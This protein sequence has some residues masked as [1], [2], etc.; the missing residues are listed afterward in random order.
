MWDT[1]MKKNVDPIQG[2]KEVSASDMGSELSPM[3]P[4]DAFNPPAQQ[5]ID[6]DELH[7]FLKQLVDE[8]IELKK[9]IEDL[10]LALE[11][12]KNKKITSNTFKYAHSF[13]EFFH[14][15]F[16]PHN[17]KEESQLFKLL[18]QKL[19]EKGEHSS[20]ENPFTGIQVLEDDHIHAIRLGG[21]FS[22][23]LNLFAMLNHPE[24]KSILLEDTYRIAFE[25][26]ELLE[27]HIFRED[28]IIIGLAQDLLTKEELDKAH[29]EFIL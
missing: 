22:H 4:P 29:S 1:K 8:H 24:S 7:P 18:H 25:R 3:S 26:K 27:L 20:G 2:Q 5:K 15:E 16:V 9:K 23:L 19:L 6:Y 28:H 13:L 17:K 21:I 12:F 10:N 11:D 14:Q